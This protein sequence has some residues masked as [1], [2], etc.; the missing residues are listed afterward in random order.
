[1]IRISF[2]TFTNR[3]NKN[4]GS[5]PSAQAICLSCIFQ[6]GVIYKQAMRL[7]QEGASGMGEGGGVLSAPT[8]SRDTAIIKPN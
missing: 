7:E 4:E 2:A 1:M 6:S 8:D 3:A 5:C